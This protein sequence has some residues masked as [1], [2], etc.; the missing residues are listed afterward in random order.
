MED[1]DL[2]KNDPTFRGLASTHL[3]RQ[4]GLQTGSALWGKSPAETEKT[5]VE[6]RVT[7]KGGRGG[8]YEMRVLVVVGHAVDVAVLVHGERHPVQGLGA[9]HAAEAA[10]VVRVAQRLQDL[11]PQMTTLETPFWSAPF[12]RHFGEFN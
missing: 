3:S 5:N 12:L 7:S 2:I 8:A 4:D 11:R 1:D 9:H 6:R 10:G